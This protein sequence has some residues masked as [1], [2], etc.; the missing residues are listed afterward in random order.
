MVRRSIICE[1][2]EERKR[3]QGERHEPAG[4]SR[5][6]TKPSS[7][8]LPPT[9]QG[10]NLTSRTALWSG[11]AEEASKN[12]KKTERAPTAVLLCVGQEEMDEAIGSERGG[13]R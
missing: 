2:R 6:G 9:E 11:N 12:T 3:R 1:E 8:S 5:K 7:P 4:I 13:E 10:K